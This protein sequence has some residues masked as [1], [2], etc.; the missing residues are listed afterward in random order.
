MKLII[1]LMMMLTRNY[2]STSEQYDTDDIHNPDNK[3]Y[4]EEIA[5]N[6]GVSYEEVTQEMFNE[7]YP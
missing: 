3:E 7:R 6:E 4:V 5:F 2:S 1:I